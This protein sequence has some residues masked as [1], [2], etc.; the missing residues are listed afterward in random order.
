MEP[1]LQEVLK[2]VDEGRTA[3]DSNTYYLVDNTELW[4]L[5]QDMLGGVLTPEEVASEWDG[6][7]SQLMQ[8]KG[9]DGF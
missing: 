9:I 5:Y 6:I 1:Y 2:Y 3:I 4:R 8:D 7:F